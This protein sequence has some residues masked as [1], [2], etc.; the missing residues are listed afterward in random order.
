MIKLF[1]KINPFHRAVAR[2]LVMGDGGGGEHIASAKG[3]NLV[4]GSVSSPMKMANNYCKS[5]QS[6]QL[7]LLNE[8]KSIHRLDLSGSTVLGGEQ[9]LPCPPPLLATA[10]SH[11][12]SLFILTV[13]KLAFTP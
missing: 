13:L 1:A 4:G 7:S 2:F 8:N 11:Q 3:M 10:L 12:V 6:K 5:L 9:L